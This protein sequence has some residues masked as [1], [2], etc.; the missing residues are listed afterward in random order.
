M[1]GPHHRGL[2]TVSSSPLI[3]APAFSVEEG[4]RPCVPAPDLDLLTQHSLV[5]R[6]SKWGPWN[7]GISAPESSLEMKILRP[8]PRPPES[9]TLRWSPASNL[10]SDTSSRGS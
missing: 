6:F 7:S 3:A 4:R 2:A 5:Q 8:H 1:H 9:E 10:C